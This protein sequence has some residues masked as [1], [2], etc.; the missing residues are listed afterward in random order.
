MIAIATHQTDRG[1]LDLRLG[2]GHYW[3]V[4]SFTN[5]SS[6]G[7]SIPLSEHEA[8]VWLADNLL[9]DRARTDIHRLPD[10]TLLARVIPGVEQVIKATADEEDLLDLLEDEGVNLGS[11]RVAAL[12]D[13]RLIG[14]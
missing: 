4:K 12:W 3:L 6:Y 7:A 5:G 2:E 10:G 9:N 14:F 8:I 1:I 13:C 11:C